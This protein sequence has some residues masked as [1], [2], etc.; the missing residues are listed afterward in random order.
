MHLRRFAAGALGLGLTA[1]LGPNPLLDA[2]G[3]GSES[4]AE[5]TTGDGDSGDGDSDSRDGDGDGDTGSGD[6]DGD[7]GDGDSGDGDG[8]SNAVHD[9]DETDLD[10]GG[11]CPACEPGE[12]CL[13]PGDCDSLVC[14]EQVC[15]TPSC[16]DDVRNGDEL[17]VDC[18]GSCRFC[19]HSVYVDEFDDFEGSDSLWPGLAMF[20]DGVFAVSYVALATEEIRVRWFDD[21][22][23]PFGAG[24][25][26]TDLL[27]EPTIASQAMIE[28]DDLDDHTVYMV[29]NGEDEMSVNRDV[30]AAA[31]APGKAA[32]L[33]PIYQGP[34]P[35]AHADMILDGAIATYVWED[36]GRI[37]LR[38][39]DFDLLGG[40]WITLAQTAN[41]NYANRPGRN[42]TLARG[43][44]VTVVAWAACDGVMT[45]ACDIELRRF[46]DGWVEDAPVSLNLQPHPYGD[47]QLAIADD[48]RVALTWTRL[49]NGNREVWAAI[50]DAELAPDGAAWLLQGGLET[51]LSPTSDVVALED[52]TFAF[53]WPDALANRVHIRRFI[54]ADTPLVT[55]VG[56]EAPWPTTDLPYWVRMATSGNLVAVVWSGKSDNVFQ[57]QGQVLSF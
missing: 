30:F 56:D 39:Y 24:E 54:G 23:T 8:C 20:S 17:D 5:T 35:V 29:L 13:E 15:A 16:S 10:C 51:P 40:S 44:E 21:L 52:G 42:P 47:P 33:A 41:P 26:V 49:D 38:R 25:E 3:D 43:P 22:A 14:D 48:G 31:R 50:V 28:T 1:C 9:G 27:T 7:S 55:D 36:D 32:E 2:G 6:G 37:Y 53:G 18:G 57:I 4:G 11:S 12:A 19:E 46:D 45:D 34:N